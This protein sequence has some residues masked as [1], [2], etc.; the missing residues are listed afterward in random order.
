MRVRRKLR[1]R[2]TGRR[3]EE[4][5][6]I[7]RYCQKCIESPIN[8]RNTGTILP[9]S[10]SITDS[11]PSRPRLSLT[12]HPIP[13][14]SMRYHSTRSYRYEAASHHIRSRV[15]CN[16]MTPHYMTWHDMI[17]QSM[18]PHNITS[19]LIISQSTWWHHMTPRHITMHDTT[20]YQVTSR[21]RSHN[22]SSHS[23]QYS[24]IAPLPPLPS[25]SS[26]CYL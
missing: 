16:N 9:T 15:R 5:W 2:E 8:L 4:G 22:D 25:S 6:I 10:L 1:Q 20:S 12:S 18:T 26:F 23:M 14:H 24:P 7:M 21:H 3:E 17:S 19:H 13:T 11:F